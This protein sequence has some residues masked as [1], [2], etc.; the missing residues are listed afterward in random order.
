VPARARGVNM[1]LAE[2][3]RYDV[4]TVGP[5]LSTASLPD[6]ARQVPLP[7]SV[8]AR[9]QAMIASGKLAPGSK[10]PSQR[11]LC[12]DFGVSRGV[13]REAISLLEASGLLRTEAA[14]GTFVSEP[15]REAP[16]LAALAMAGDYS[17][18][19]VC[20]FRHL[21]EGH[22][23]KLAALRI[24]DAELDELNLNLSVF[25]EQTRALDFAASARTDV[26]FHRQI[27][28]IAGVQLFTDLHGGCRQLLLETLTMPPTMRNRGWEPVVEHERILEALRRRDPDEALYYAQSHI[29][30]S[31]ERLGILLANDVV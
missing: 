25:K 21:I 14:R 28:E 8:A 20:R 27:V 7:K 15:V 6:A 19:D 24:T 4:D 9:I 5:V 17:K 3:A 12:T 10:L 31:A 16:P 2:N 1:K 26:D 30:R 13:V 11:V 18:L 22:T 29:V 23:A